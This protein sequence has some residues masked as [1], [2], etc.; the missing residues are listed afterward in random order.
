[1]NITV[2]QYNAV[3]EGQKMQSQLLRAQVNEKADVIH[4]L[5]DEI[6]KLREGIEGMK[7]ALQV[8][9]EDNARLEQ[10]LNACEVALAYPGVAVPDE[11][12]RSAVLDGIQRL[13][14]EVASRGCRRKGGCCKK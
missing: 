2:Q 11:K 3:V 4:Q 10:K 7:S 9:Q 12:L 14:A 1:V 13:Q 8:V 6:A 5:V